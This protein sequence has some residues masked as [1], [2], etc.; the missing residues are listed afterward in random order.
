MTPY[1]LVPFELEGKIGRNPAYS[2]KAR[3]ISMKM[4]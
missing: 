3:P 1:P 4:G 2:V